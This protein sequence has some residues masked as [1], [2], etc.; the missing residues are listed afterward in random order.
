MASNLPNLPRNN[1]P[2]MRAFDFGGGFIESPGGGRP[3][4]FPSD[5][6]GGSIWGPT[7]NPILIGGGSGEP[8]TG[9]SN[10]ATLAQGALDKTGSLVDCLLSPGT[11]LLR[12]V[13]LVLGLIC[14]I[15]AIYLY[16]PTQQIA[17]PVI[18]IARGALES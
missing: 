15:G 1:L 13:L 10:A 12:L 18:K 3:G 9:K 11:C 16:K 6:T 2:D 8:I 7:N 17:A 5:P 4:G 14:I